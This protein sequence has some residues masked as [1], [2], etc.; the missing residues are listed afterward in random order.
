MERVHGDSIGRINSGVSTGIV[1][2]GLTVKQVQ[3]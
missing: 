3:G 2:R 1:E